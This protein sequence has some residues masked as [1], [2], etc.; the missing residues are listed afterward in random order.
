MAEVELMVNDCVQGVDGRTGQ[1]MPEAL[2]GHPPLMYAL[3]RKYMQRWV[4][5]PLV[6]LLDNLLEASIL[7]PGSSRS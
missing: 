3:W 5:K 7:N 1:P 6:K 4:K 2:R